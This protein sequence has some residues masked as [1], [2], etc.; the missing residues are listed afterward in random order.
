MPS[1]SARTA[2]MVNPGLLANT[3]IEWR[4]SASKVS[5]L[6]LYAMDDLLVPGIFAV[7]A[8]YRLP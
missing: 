4:T 2:T 8:L 1:A 3:R 7:A 6:E 5:I